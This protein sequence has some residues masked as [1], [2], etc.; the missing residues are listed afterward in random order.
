MKEVDNF[1][2]AEI[3]SR[4]RL[5]KVLNKYF[6]A[7]SYTDNNLLVLSGASSG[8]SHCLL[9]TDIGTTVGIGSASISL[10]FLISDGVVK[11]F[12]T[13]MGKKKNK[14]RMIA[15]LARS[16]L[17]SIENIVAKLLI[18][19][20]IS[21]EEFTLVI[22]KEQNY[23]RIKES[24]RAKDDQLTEV[25]WNKLIDHGKRIEKNQRISLKLK[26]DVLYQSIKSI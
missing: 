17:N 19:S 2:I 3:N 18:D 10:V 4:K 23:F 11:M 7:P 16:K 1:L 6:I 21:H 13:T 15:Y 22:N 8:V 12:L 24:I 5:I 9:T 20:N 25:E 14:Q 26:N